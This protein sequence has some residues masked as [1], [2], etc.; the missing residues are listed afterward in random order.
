MQNNMSY[1]L[2]FDYD[3]VIV[4]S[5]DTFYDQFLK[6]CANENL[7]GIASHAE[8]LNLYERNMYESMRALGLTNTQIL[9]VVLSMRKGLLDNHDA[10]TLVEGMKEAIIKC[11][12]AHHLFI[13]TSNESRIV[14]SFLRNHNLDCFTEIIG[15]EKEPSKTKNIEYIKEKYPNSRYFYIGDTKGDIFEGKKADVYTVAVTWG[16]HD[17]NRLKQA[18][19]DHIVRSPSELCQLFSAEI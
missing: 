2:I 8:F 17:E 16:W 15:S 11:A 19:P 7:S 9:N 5:F 13:V 3:G 10:I 18:Y 6:A 1:T 4:E 14:Q 12:S